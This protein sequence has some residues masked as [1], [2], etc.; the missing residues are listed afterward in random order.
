MREECV[1]PPAGHW[2][3]TVPQGHRLRIIDLEGGQGVDFLCYN[4]DQHA[5]RYH[6][7]NTLKA[8]LTLKLSAGHKL[9]RLPGKFS[10]R[11]SPLRNGS[12]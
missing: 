7:P 6:A 11:P 4:A 10:R 1:I 12:T 8:A 5:E 3:G 2:S 9:Y